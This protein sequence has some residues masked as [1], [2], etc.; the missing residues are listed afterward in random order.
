MLNIVGTFDMTPH[1]TPRLSTNAAIEHFNFMESSVAAVIRLMTQPGQRRFGGS[2][3][4]RFARLSG[5]AMGL[6]GEKSVKKGNLTQKI[7]ITHRKVKHLILDYLM[8]FGSCPGFIIT[9]QQLKSLCKRQ[10]WSLI[11][12][13]GKLQ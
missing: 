9:F 12:Y 11:S 8:P 10:E 4:P 7:R 3:T 2:S 6:R 13:L 5:S 1:I